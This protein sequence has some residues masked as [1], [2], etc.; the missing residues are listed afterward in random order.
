MTE[1]YLRNA[2]RSKCFV[3]APSPSHCESTAQ[4][5]PDCVPSGSTR[6]EWQRNCL[7]EPHE[8]PLGR[9]AA[10]GSGGAGSGAGAGT[11]CQRAL[12]GG[13]HR[14]FG[15]R[16]VQAGPAGPRQPP[17][18]GRSEVQPGEA[19]GTLEVD[20]Q[21]VPGPP[22]FH[23]GE[24]RQHARS[25]QGHLRRGRP[26]EV[27]R[28]HGPQ[29][30]VSLAARIQR[31]SGRLSPDAFQRVHAR[32]AQRRRHAGRALLRPQ[33]A[34]REPEGGHGP[35]PA[36]LRVR[37]LPRDLERRDAGCLR[38]PGYRP[39]PRAPQ[40]RAAGHPA[41]GPPSQAF[42][43]SELPALPNPDSGRAHRSGQRGHD[44]SAL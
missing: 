32:R 17:R 11:Q 13:E 39:L 40:L 1:G 28:S 3:P 15:R 7:F 9:C 44:Y 4:V 31:R 20:S 33:G 42:P 22:G 38:E 6:C 16:S 29:A 19:R 21:G 8:T 14:D 10:L 23:P 37:Q 5:P 27:P 43:G 12:H 41:A 2:P 18:A 35:P 24:P 36:G 30:C 25:R 34:V 26:L